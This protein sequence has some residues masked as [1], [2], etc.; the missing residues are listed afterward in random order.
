M[1]PPESGVAIHVR[2]PADV[3]AGL[4]AMAA[5]DGIT[6]AELLRRIARDYV[7]RGKK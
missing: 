5:R 7:K 1:A 4:D 2:I 6:R 3:L